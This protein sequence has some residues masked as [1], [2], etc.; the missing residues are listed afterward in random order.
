MAK[1][2]FT[3]KASADDTVKADWASNGKKKISKSFELG[4]F[5]LFELGK[6]FIGIS[7]N[8]SYPNGKAWLG[9]RTVTCNDATN[10]YTYLQENLADDATWNQI[11]RTIANSG[12]DAKIDNMGGFVS[13]KDM[14]KPTE[15]VDSACGKKSVS[16]AKRKPTRA[17]AVKAS[18]KKAVKS[19][20][21]RRAVKASDV[22]ADRPNS[23]PNSWK[24]SQRMTYKVTEDQTKG[25]R[26]FPTDID[27]V[28]K[29]LGE[30]QGIWTNPTTGWTG[31]CEIYERDLDDG[32]YIF[33][34]IFGGNELEPDDILYDPNGFD[35]YSNK[36]KFTIYPHSGAPTFAD[37]IEDFKRKLKKE[38][39]YLKKVDS[40]KS[41]KAVKASAKQYEYIPLYKVDDEWSAYADPSDTLDGS[42]DSILKWA[43]SS[44]CADFKDYWDSTAKIVVW[45]KTTDSDVREYSN[46]EVY[47]MLDKK[48]SGKSVNSSVKRK[49]AKRTIKASAS[50][51]IRAY[52]RIKAASEYTDWEGVYGEPMDLSYELNGYDDSDMLECVDNYFNSVDDIWLNADFVTYNGPDDWSV[53]A[54][55]DSEAVRSDFGYFLEQNYPEL[56]D[57]LTETYTTEPDDI[58]DSM[59]FNRLDYIIGN[60]FAIQFYP[61]NKQISAP[62]IDID[63]TGNLKS[64][65]EEAR[66]AYETNRIEAYKAIQNGLGAFLANGITAST[67]VKAG[68]NA[69]S[70]DGPLCVCDWC[71]AGIESHEGKQVVYNVISDLDIEPDEK[72]ICDWC[73]S[74]ATELYQISP[75]DIT[76]SKKAVKCAFDEGDPWEYQ[77]SY[78]YYY[79]EEPPEHIAKELERLAKLT[80][81]YKDRWFEKFDELHP[82]ERFSSVDPH[83]DVDEAVGYTLDEA[84]YSPDDIKAAEDIDDMDYITGDDE[85]TD[86]GFG[87]T[88]DGE[89]ITESMVEEL[90]R[91]AREIL[92]KSEVAKYDEYAD[93]HNFNYWATS[94]YVQESFDITFTPEFTSDEMWSNKFVSGNLID[95]DT[96]ATYKIY[97]N[98][99]VKTGEVVDIDVNDV[100]MRNSYAVDSYLSRIDI[101][102][103]KSWVGRLVAPVAMKIYNG[104]TN[105]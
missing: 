101:D 4:N 37:S 51:K 58:G 20:A 82:G 41:S 80:D 85:P 31:D 14:R 81:M 74:E 50:A 2:K 30:M 5:F 88:S 49:P 13:D 78:D 79:D 3:V 83:P 64:Q 28:Y 16:S 104:T 72:L 60:D 44:G 99:R 53:D 93:L 12:F 56:Y 7:I 59:S 19:S 62:Q 25:E 63:A 21:K 6:D 65:L 54:S 47:N 91:I 27:D 77:E 70:T 33:S 9:A 94:P 36:P 48:T 87:F 84:E 17:Q 52:K 29:A 55:L 68:I 89:P 73:E 61:N 15:S 10:L 45:D 24:S 35:Y 92:E 76:S 11:E 23:A 67:A 43:K 90:E 18:E 95:W 40:V 1:K 75:D 57:T 105:I 46:K 86:L 97:I 22:D 8:N 71:L 66:D 98:V 102:A 39:S 100:D 26:S 69:P 42:L 34:L 96:S 32:S 103:I 38:Y